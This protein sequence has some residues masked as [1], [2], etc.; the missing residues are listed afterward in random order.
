MRRARHR[1]PFCPISTHKDGRAAPATHEL[2]VDRQPCALS[3]ARDERTATARHTRDHRAWLWGNAGTRSTFPLSL[4]PHFHS[5]T[6]QSRPRD[7]RA[8]CRSPALRAVM[9][10]GMKGQQQRGTPEATRRGSVAM[11]GR[12]ARPRC[13]FCPNSTQKHGRAAPATHGLHVDRQRCAL[14][15]ALG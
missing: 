15:W 2:H 6:Q 1:C 4:L 3:W 11:Q 14:S 9:G 13:P 8:A 5:K 10:P 12:R 7:P